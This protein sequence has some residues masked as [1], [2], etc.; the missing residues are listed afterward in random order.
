MTISSNITTPAAL[1]YYNESFPASVEN[2]EYRLGSVVL[3]ETPEGA[4]G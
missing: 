4:P 3:E 2:D 1:I